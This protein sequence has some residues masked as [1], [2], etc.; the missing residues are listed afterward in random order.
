MNTHQPDKASVNQNTLT[1]VH[2]AYLNAH[3]IT[4]EV[5]AAA[6][7]FSLGGEI[8]FPWKDGEQVT[9]QRRPWPEPP[10]GL[11]GAKYLWETG[12]PLHLWEIRPPSDA[13]LN[14]PVILA[15]GTKQALAVASWAPDEYAVYGMAGCRGWVNG[16]LSRFEGR[17]VFVMLDADAGSNLDVYEAGEKLHQLLEI[18]D[19]RVKFTRIPAQGKD[20]IDDFLAAGPPERRRRIIA[21]LCEMAK[22]KP[23]ERRPRPSKTGPVAAQSATPL[24]AATY[25]SSEVA[26]VAAVAPPADGAALLDETVR[27]ITAYVAFSR[28]EHAAAAAL[29]AA[30]THAVRGLQVAPRLR[31]KSPVKQCGKTRLLQVLGCL[32]HRPQP[33]ANVSAAALVRSIGAD[34]CT[35]ILDEIDAVFRREA[36]TEQAEDLRGILN[37]GFDR[38]STYDR[39]NASTGTVER[40]PTFALA[41]I[42]GIGDLPDT[43]EDRAVILPMQRKTADAQVARF[44][45]RRDPPALRNLAARL[46]AWIGP[47]ADQI[48]AAEPEMPSGMS[49]RAEDTWEPLL[50][51]ADAAGGHWPGLA[52]GVA[53]VMATAA[54]MA[55]AETSASARLLIDLRTVFGDAD[56]MPTAL[57]L[58]KLTGL[59]GAPWADWSY[60]RPLS[61]RQLADMLRPFGPRPHD[62]KT[63]GR[64]AKSYFR[65]DFRDAWQRYASPTLVSGATAATAATAQVNQVAA[66][67]G[68]AAQSATS[69]RN[70]TFRQLTEMPLPDPYHGPVLFSRPV[71]APPAPPANGFTPEQLAAQEEIRARLSR[72]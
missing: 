50:A 71:P 70:D 10:G 15:E 5:I 17:D 32:V 12:R 47:L 6:G 57:I 53:R 49:D 24:P 35:L 33:T 58:A 48:G 65:A 45:I 59:D 31:V 66:G 43:I 16:G 20:G 30:A 9:A 25:L 55:D 63:D 4:D 56:S 64:V 41:I 36:K 44:R 62:V 8:I 72:A 60:G 67:S 11:H 21:K 14:G 46:A 40:W 54:A 26:A 51:V 37:A 29:Y 38:G 69:D 7:I 19:A 34:P 22:S 23:A 52:R 3:A 28:P 18:E 13:Y 2:R 68:V 39:Y 1:D 61:A 42:A 27:A